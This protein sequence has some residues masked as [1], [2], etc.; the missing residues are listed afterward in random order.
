MGIPDRDP[1]IEFEFLLEPERTLEPFRTSLWTAHGQTEMTDDANRKW[2]FRFHR[3]T[4]GIAAGD[5]QQSAN[6]P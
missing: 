3:F 2:N 5:A 1:A 6:R 4:E